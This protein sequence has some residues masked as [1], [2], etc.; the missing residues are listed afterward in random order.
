[1]SST[2]SI[3][4]D[5]QDGDDRTGGVELYVSLISSSTNAAADDDESKGVNGRT[6]KPELSIQPLLVPL[7]DDNESRSVE[8]NALVVALRW[9]L[10]VELSMLYRLS[11]KKRVRVT[12]GRQ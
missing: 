7:M 11:R 6:G 1:M 2:H 8:V 9:A 3:E 12:L 4:L 5:G 10:P